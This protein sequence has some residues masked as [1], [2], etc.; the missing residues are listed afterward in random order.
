MNCALIKSFD[1]SFKRIYIEFIKVKEK[2]LQNN[3]LFKLKCYQYKIK[4]Y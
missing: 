1:E 2:T 4:E 3:I